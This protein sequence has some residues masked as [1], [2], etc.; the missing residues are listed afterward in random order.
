MNIVAMQTKAGSC[1]GFLICLGKKFFKDEVAEVDKKILPL[2]A[3][4]APGGVN[5]R[6]MPTYAIL[7]WSSMEVRQ[8]KI[9]DLV[10]G[11]TDPEFHR[12]KRIYFYRPPTVVVNCACAIDLLIGDNKPQQ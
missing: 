4:A 6:V 7:L 3:S 12:I 5:P 10:Y 9:N 8:F 2:L 11:F 1:A